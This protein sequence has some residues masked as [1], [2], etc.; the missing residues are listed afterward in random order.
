[1]NACIKESKGVLV[2]C[3]TCG[4]LF[5]EPAEEDHTRKYRWCQTCSFK[6]WGPNP[7]PETKARK[8]FKVVWEYKWIILFFTI[9]NIIG[10]Y[11]SYDIVE[12]IIHFIGSLFYTMIFLALKN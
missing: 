4:R 1:M 9:Y 11:S 2:T 3:T 8:I 7:Q 6:F 5:E 12:F 10:A